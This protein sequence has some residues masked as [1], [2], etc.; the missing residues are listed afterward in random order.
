[1][2]FRVIFTP[3]LGWV[4]KFVITW[5]PNTFAASI[6]AMQHKAIG[7]PDSLNSFKT[8]ST[9]GSTVISVPLKAKSLRFLAA[10]NPPGITKASMSD[11]ALRSESFSTAPR[12]ILALSMST[13][14]FSGNSGVDSVF[15]YSSTTSMKAVL[16]GLLGAKTH[17]QSGICLPP[18]N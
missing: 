18:T 7:F 10:P 5:E 2:T 9:S 17:G 12:D 4:N 1:M 13:F 16:S 8:L 6:G 11:V 15:G 3:G 14:L